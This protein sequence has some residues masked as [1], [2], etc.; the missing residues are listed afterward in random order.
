M[1]DTDTLPQWQDVAEDFK[2]AFPLADHSELEKR[3]N[4]QRSLAEHRQYVEHPQNVSDRQSLRW[5]MDV[6]PAAAVDRSVANLD[7]KEARRRFD[8]G[9]PRDDDYM[10]IADYEAS[11]KEESEQGL[12]ESVGHAVA[13]IPTT[14]AKFAALGPLALPEMALE[15]TLEGATGRAV[16]KGGEAYSPKN[17]L[18]AAEMGVINAAVLGRLGK[19]T[20]GITNPFAKWAGAT[21]AGVG[22]LQTAQVAAS[23]ADKILPEEY[24][25]EANFGIIGKALDGKLGEAFKDAVVEAAT[26]GGFS[27]A[28]AFGAIANKYDKLRSQGVKPDS[29]K[30]KA[31]LGKVVEEAK[32]ASSPVEDAEIFK[33]FGIE[34]PK[35]EAPVGAPDATVQPEAAKPKTPREAATELE[36]QLHAT[37]QQIEDAKRR[38]RAELQRRQFGLTNEYDQAKS[39]RSD[40]EARAKALRKQVDRARDEAVAWEASQP[41]EPPLGDELSRDPIMTDAPVSESE[42]KTLDIYQARSELEAAKAYEAE[43]Q[44]NERA[45]LKGMVKPLEDAT[46]AREAAQK[47]LDD[48]LRESRRSGLSGFRNTPDSYWGEGFDRPNPIRERIRDTLR[49][50]VAF[51]DME[52]A[53]LPDLVPEQEAQ[54]PTLLLPKPSLMDRLKGKGKVEVKTPE[55]PTVEPREAKDFTKPPEPKESDSFLGFDPIDPTK[56][57]D[58]RERAVLEGRYVDGRTQ[59][60]IGDE[61]GLTKARIQQIEAAA[62]AKLGK[63]PEEMKEAAW[64]EAFNRQQ[65]RTPGASDQ[66]EGMSIEDKARAKRYKKYTLIAKQEGLNPADLHGQAGEI[67]RIDRETTPARNEILKD[68]YARLKQYKVGPSTIHHAEESDAVKGLDIVAD[69][70]VREGRLLDRPDSSGGS[71]LEQ[72]FTIL[73]NKSIKP[74]TVEQ[75]YEEALEFLKEM[76]DAEVTRQSEREAFLSQAEREIG[77]TEIAEEALREADAEV[78]RARRGNQAE[79]RSTVE[80][81]GAETGSESYDAIRSGPERGDD[82][83]DYGGEPRGGDLS[84][85]DYSRFGDAPPGTQ[86]SF[87]AGDYGDVSATQGELFDRTPEQKIKPKQDLAGQTNFLDAVKDFASDEAGSLDLQKIKDFGEHAYERIRGGMKAAGLAIKGFGHEMYPVTHSIS[88]R[89][90]NAMATFAGSRE[91]ATRATPY[92]IDKVMGDAPIENRKLWG[93]ALAEMRKRYARMAY[94]ARGD[95]QAAAEIESFV[96]AKDSPLKTEAE[97]RAVLADPKFR[98]MTDRYRGFAKD[99]MDPLFKRAQGIE[100]TDPINTFTQ[101]PGMPVSF[102][103][104]DPKPTFLGSSRGSLSAPKARKLGAAE[105]A[106]LKGTNFDTDLGAIIDH[107]LKSRVELANKAQMYRVAEEEGQAFWSKSV[108]ERSTNED[109]EV[110]RRLPDVNPPKGTQAAQKGEKNLYVNEKL[111]GEMKNALDMNEASEGTKQIR[112][113]T[114]LA[115]AANLFVSTT[116]FLYHS[117]NQLSQFFTK[118]GMRYSD[119]YKNA[120]DRFNNTPGFQSKMMELAK[121]GADKPSYSHEQGKLNLLRYGS[122]V[123]D[124]ISDVMRATSS[125]AFDRL[126]T[127]KGPNGKP[128]FENTEAAKRDFVNQ[129]GQYN[130]RAQNGYVR[131]LRDSGFGPFATAGT[132]YIEQSVGA[133]GLN[134]GIKGE[135]LYAKAYLRANFLKNLAIMG[136]TVAAINYAAWGRV[137]GD[138]NT[139]L[140]CIKVGERNGKSISIDVTGPLLIRRAMRTTGLLRMFEGE[141]AGEP[142]T[143]TS[144]KAV[145]DVVHAFIHPA[146]GPAA[147]FAITAATGKNSLGWQ[148]AERAKE[149]E[150]QPVKNVKGA[151]L[152]VNPVVSAVAGKGDKPA[153]ER[154]MDLLGP[155]GLKYRDRPPGSSKRR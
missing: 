2:T 64:N 136:G 118:P 89:L 138:E 146:M 105:Q 123:L 56:P 97:F 104:S 52:P 149:G 109:G 29:E 41:K 127:I 39:M 42:Q 137:D 90:G 77:S 129:L 93:T 75:A 87:L 3:F 60:D 80:G 122:K 50:Q 112:K 36:A 7:Y 120:L 108:G 135:G 43:A 124:G 141:R 139:P 131:F 66:F 113:L 70:F 5:V 114:N 144:D 79:A 12:G 17:L 34:V 69:G 1:N 142:A 45:G 148:V 84:R 57:L 143:A 24:R 74:K 99:V 65:E 126:A 19:W 54:K 86:T 92:W 145:K 133:L 11:R 28:H 117:Q 59:E 22:E 49:G 20:Q 35:A 61:R 25:T 101:M 81:D 55:Q 62:L 33:S 96:G 147:E 30:M 16:T 53:P 98:E 125:D 27:A 6:N 121:I 115:T 78:D 48:L 119:L 68:A 132:N 37:D 71:A 100:E 10:K 130:R 88:Q 9:K 46:A 106:F 14:I 67:L 94:S 8:A 58:K 140:F 23:L 44:K 152:N 107:T 40:L 21:A 85:V 18:P 38:E 116:E 150:S 47:R 153:E 154:A 15:Q 13:S 128:L 110:F 63:T 151:L 51:P 76:R 4:Q 83:F 103:S 111:W 155:F 102:K 32:Q 26:M 72:L 91:Y 134:P 31:E 95:A 82:S 73:K